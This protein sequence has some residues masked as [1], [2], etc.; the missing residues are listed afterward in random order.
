MKRAF[1]TIGIFLSAIILLASCSSDDEEE[2][3]D[4]FPERLELSQIAGT[5]ISNNI[6]H[7]W[8]MM[9]YGQDGGYGITSHKDKY[10]ITFLKN[11]T[12]ECK[13]EN[14]AFHGRYVCNEDGSFSFTEYNGVDLTVGKDEP[15]IHANI[16][17]C[18][19]FAINEQSYYLV[20]FYSD[21]DFYLF[22]NM[23]NQ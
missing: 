10:R 21:K 16:K 13:T 6:Y 5:T 23:D 20:L 1:K 3:G 22:W 18:K 17:N 11:G 2:F 4:L 9:G 15:L 19:R 8:E 7:S 14:N 12:F